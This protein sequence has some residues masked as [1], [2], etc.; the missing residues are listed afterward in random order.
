MHCAPWLLAGPP[1]FDGPAYTVQLGSPDETLLLGLDV[2]PVAHAESGAA[3]P[4]EYTAGFTLPLHKRAAVWAGD[5]A[6]QAAVARALSAVK[7]GAR[8]VILEFRCCEPELLGELK[9]RGNAF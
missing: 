7:P 5:W 6:D 9:A 2:A 4:G 1:H 3:V 8:C